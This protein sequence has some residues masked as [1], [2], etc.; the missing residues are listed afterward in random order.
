[1][2]QRDRETYRQTG[3]RWI[4]LGSRVYPWT[5]LLL[6]DLES[7][8]HCMA[9]LETS[10]PWA[11][12]VLHREYRIIVS[13]A[14]APRSVCH[15]PLCVPRLWVSVI[16]GFCQFHLDSLFS[17]TSLVLFVGS[18]QWTFVALNILD[19]QFFLV[20]AYNPSWECYGI[21]LTKNR[22]LRG[23]AHLENIH[24]WQVPK[25]YNQ[26]HTSVICTSWF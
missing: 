4:Q 25:W 13:R 21:Q 7:Y 3:N 17:N 1:M 22:P 5:D 24:Y 12:E 9:P 14:A 20:Q 11:Q 6:W 23:F 10:L 8:P 15:I 19:L 18:I 26:A 16:Q 2:R